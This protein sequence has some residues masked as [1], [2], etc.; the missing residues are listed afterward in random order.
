MPS[1]TP[2]ERLTNKPL[3]AKPGY[4]WR[5]VVA[6][7]CVLLL[8]VFTTAAGVHFHT[9]SSTDD[10]HCQL[11]FAAHAPVAAAAPVALL[12]Q[13]VWTQVTAVPAAP[14]TS[15]TSIFDLNIRPPPTFL[16]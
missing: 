13:A 11:C 9:S 2:N 12:M 8:A 1:R 6:L 7:A 5:A 15:R 14:R 3:T 4:K 10:P 16:S